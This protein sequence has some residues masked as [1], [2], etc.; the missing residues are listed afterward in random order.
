MIE[1]VVG[2]IGEQVERGGGRAVVGAKFG[3]C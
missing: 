2:R 3:Y 1:A